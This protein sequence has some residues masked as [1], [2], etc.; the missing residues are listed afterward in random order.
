MASGVGAQ[1]QAIAIAWH[2]YELTGSTIALGLLA[3]FRLV[4]FMTLSLVGGAMADVMD[5]RL[6]LMVT[7]SLQSGV[8]LFLVASVVL[9]IDAPWPIYVASFLGG[10]FAAFDGPARQA[11]IPNLVPR[12]EL[13][14]A[15]TMN[16]LVRHTATVIGP[17]VAG[18]SLATLG[19]GPTFGVNA[20][21]HILVV[22]ALAAM[23]AVRVAPAPASTGNIQRIREGLDYA[24]SEPLVLLPLVLDFITRA[25][26]SPRGV[27]PVFARDIYAVGPVG[28]GW[29][30]SAGAVGGIVG[31]L[32]LGSTLHVPRPVFVMLLMYFLEGLFNGAFG[33]APSLLLAWL[34]LFMGGI[35]NVVAEVIFASVVQLRT[36]DQLR[37]RTTALTNMLSLGGPQT[38]QFEIGMLA[39]AIGPGGAVLFNGLAGAGTTVV[40]ALLPGLQ[41][42]IGTRQMSDLVTSPSYSGQRQGE[43][44]TRQ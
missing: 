12:E 39:A 31:G 33:I 5:R 28:L 22:V 36:P 40:F 20:I 41:A 8:A 43:A 24:R 19:T 25:L 38:G 37:G 1:F 10:A 27:L 13:A 4:P 7:Q 29:L 30:S 2:I 34:A 9:G 23:R 17:G 21:S 26:G 16:T 14:N 6:L 42:H 3:L 18:L 11:L 32:L 35:C 44:A 15:L